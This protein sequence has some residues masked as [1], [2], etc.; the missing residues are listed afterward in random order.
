[1]SEHSY[2][3][4]DLGAETGRVML[5]HLSAGRLSLEEIH[6]FRTPVVTM[7]PG[8]SM[9]WG[10][11]QILAEIKAGLGKLAKAGTRVDSI[12]VDSWGVDY[13]L[14]GRGQP[15]LW[16][17][18]HYRDARTDSVYAPVR[19][20]L[21]DAFIFEQTGIQFMPIN[22]LYQLVADCRFCHELLKQVDAFLT[23]GDYF[24]FLLSGVPCVD[25]SN[26]ST[27]Q[28]YNPRT[29][30]WSTELIE[31]AGL[32]PNIF[33]KILPPGTVLGPL[34]NY[35]AVETGWTE[36]PPL[37]VATCSHDTQAAVAAV[38]AEPGENG[39]GDDWAFLS[40]GTWSLLGVELP[41]PLIND[42]VR[43][44]NY[45]NE[46]GFGGTTC[47]LKN[48]VGLWILQELRRT[49]ELQGDALDYAAM[50]EQ[51]K[52]SEPFRSFIHPDDPRFATPGEMPAKVAAFCRE[53]GQPEPRMP[54]EFTRCVLESLAL[55]YRAT[56]EELGQ[57]TGRTI[58][59]LHVVG[60]G[61]RSELLNQFTADAA[62]LPVIAGPVEASA[63]GNVLVQAIALE[64]LDSIQAARQVVRDSFPAQVFQPADVARWQQAYERFAGL[65]RASA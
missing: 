4:C 36:G 27:T 50:D 51:A 49:W 10:V 11:L 8:P 20:K 54:G 23:I 47:F 43:R 46:A 61:S 7:P 2:I 65:K 53:S 25:E 64:Q 30:Q 56:L 34:L 31:L 60:G 37:V 52:K 5:G 40:S 38:P 58:R 59:R 62:G 1:M 24:N 48:I 26:A 22:T 19:R 28:L 9:R 33:P 12:S 57:L 45:T 16:P 13:A 18:Y 6:R 39:A 35:L 17:P 15:L 14:I 44:L 41:D 29:R 63:A 42:E 21:G 55:L 32:P 3:A